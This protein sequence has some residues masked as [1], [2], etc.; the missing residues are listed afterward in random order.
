MLPLRSAEAMDRLSARFNYTA[1]YLVPLRC[2]IV[3]TFF[4]ASNCCIGNRIVF[5]SLRIAVAI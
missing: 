5:T 4:A 3:L 2:P 1:K